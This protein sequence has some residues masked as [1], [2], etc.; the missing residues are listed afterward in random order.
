MKIGLDRA[1]AR[2]AEVDPGVRREI[3]AEAERSALKLREETDRYV[4]NQF[5]VLEQR[6]MRILRE[7]QAGQRA[8]QSGEV[9][10]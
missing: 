7:V 4:L 8:L 3:Q 1:R 2:G 5:G 10:G 9:T 6:L